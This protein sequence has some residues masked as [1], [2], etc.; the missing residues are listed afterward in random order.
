MRCFTLKELT[1]L[2]DSDSDTEIL[3]HTLLADSRFLQLEE[4]DSNQ[5]YFIS[6]RSLFQW[7]C[8][9][10]VRL[11]LAKQVR[12][13]EHQ[14]ALTMSSLCIDD[15]WNI[16]ATKA[17]QFGNHS[18]FIES[19]NI[20]N[21]YVF[22][23][24]HI[25]SFM[26]FPTAVM[27]TVI[28]NFKAQETVH[29]T[30]EELGRQ[31]I[32]DG[33]STMNAI[34]K[35]SVCLV[36]QAREGLL[37][38]ERM[39]LEQAG[40]KLGGF[41]REWARQLEKK[42]WRRL[43]LSPRGRSLTRCLSTALM[44]NI[45]SN[46]GRLVIQQ[47][48]ANTSLLSFLAKCAGVPWVVFP[49][50]K[51]VVLGISPEDLQSSRS[52][53]DLGQEEIDIDSIVAWLQ[54]EMHLCLTYADLRA[55]GEDIA[56]SREKSLAKSLTKTE[57]VYLALRTIGRPAHYTEV[58]EVY[59]SLFSDEPSTPHNV[60]ALLGR[61]KYGVVWIGL[62]GTYA[63]REWGYQR[64]S[65]GLFDAVT[66][67]VQERYKNTSQ[68][69]PFAVIVAEM[70]KRRQVV[71]P[72][73]LTIAAH[74]NPELI[75]VGRDSFVPKEFSEE[76][77]EQISADEL[78]RILKEFENK[79]DKGAIERIDSSISEKGSYAS[80]FNQA[81]LNFKEKFTSKRH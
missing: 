23:I 35:E 50:T 42:F 32:E 68:P 55:L 21:Q 56:Q 24:A 8:R 44:C 63:L 75:R 6:N 67:I 47:C 3:K 5:S 15:R 33:F 61:K 30:F 43:K 1:D 60:Q 17:V 51:I 71:N 12:L 49:D 36:V 14:L 10:S 81:L 16:P 78:D 79:E 74:C 54:S 59:N 39:T 19:T 18:G 52:T 80:R 26:K 31:L 9:L 76:T 70:G 27:D 4:T 48:S 25:L 77:K 29:S 7:F 53:T 69:V 11:A 28:E 13:D 41:T 72:N 46:K 40:A 73:S 38:G 64:P 65:K 20:V 45:I 34:F 62:H 58:T 2:S 66:E 22:P 57:M 37:T